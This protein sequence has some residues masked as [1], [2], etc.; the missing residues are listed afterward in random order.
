MTLF[1]CM[2][3]V[4]EP[5]ARLAGIMA[6]KD[7]ARLIPLCHNIRL[8]HV[9]YGYLGS[10]SCQSDSL[11]RPLYLITHTT[12]RSVECSVDRARHAVHIEASA[13]TEGKTGVEMEALT[14]K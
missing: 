6:A 3:D 14:G 10:G 2:T 13:R 8:D 7:T 9:R 5:V 12:P 1:D 4:G 11:C